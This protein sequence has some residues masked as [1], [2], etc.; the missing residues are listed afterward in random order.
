[1]TKADKRYLELLVMQD[2][3]E[4]EYDDR[5]GKQDYQNSI[6][7]AKELLEKVRKM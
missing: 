1:M 4:M 6:K 3:R 2:I 7:R 5:S